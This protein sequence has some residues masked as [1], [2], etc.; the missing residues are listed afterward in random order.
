[1]SE[2][3]YLSN[4]N[5]DLAQKNVHSLLCASPVLSRN[6]VVTSP[7]GVSQRKC[8]LLGKW[9]LCKYFVLLG[10]VILMAY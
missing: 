1:M 5:E 8:V 9:L 10:K 3:T 4:N 7:H 2:H 6:K